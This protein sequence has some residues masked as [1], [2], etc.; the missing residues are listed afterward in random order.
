MAVVSHFAKFFSFSSPKHLEYTSD[1]KSIGKRKDGRKHP[2]NWNHG[3]RKN[4]QTRIVVIFRDPR[5]VLVRRFAV[6]TGNILSYKHTHTHTC[7]GR[8]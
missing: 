6:K 3:D 8:R 5:C 4:V 1:V 7:I 2:T